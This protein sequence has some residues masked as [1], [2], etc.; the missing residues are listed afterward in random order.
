MTDANLLRRALDALP[1]LP[2]W[3][4]ARAILLSDCC[5]VFESAG[6]MAIRNDAPGGG[7]VALVGRPDPERIELALA[8]RPHRTLLCAPEDEPHLAEHFPKWR[9]QRAVLHE[10]TAA[11]R[12]APTDSRVRPLASAD[13]L[14][15]VPEALREEL[16]RVPTDLPVV[17]LFDGEAAVSFAYAYWRTERWFDI[18][19]DTLP[20]HRRRGCARIAVSELIRR[21]CANGRQPV[22]GAI[23]RN[24]ASLQLARSIGF[25]PT[26]SVVIAVRDA[27]AD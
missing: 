20:D 24:L 25:T 7:L 19:I 21:E 18:S 16:E 15:H 8:D 6:S 4:E 27:N 12:L 11:S 10:L 3:T 9:R 1:D 2:R 26:D 17:A 22:W 13:S 23:E 14:A 5:S